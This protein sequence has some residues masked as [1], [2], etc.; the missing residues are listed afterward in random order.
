MAQTGITMQVEL[1]AD[2]V[3]MLRRIHAGVNGRSAQAHEIVPLKGRFK[4]PLMNAAIR[5]FR[6]L[7]L[8][9]AIEHRRN[10][11]CYVTPTAMHAVTPRRELHAVD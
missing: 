6:R 11:Y 10:G 8:V 5:R 1:D 9:G 7:V 3:E 4:T 2:D